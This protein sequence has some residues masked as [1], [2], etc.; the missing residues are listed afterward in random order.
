MIGWGGQFGEDLQVQ[1]FHRFHLRRAM[2]DIYIV[3]FYSENQCNNAF[4]HTYNQHLLK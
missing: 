2:V 3:E 1:I 4:L